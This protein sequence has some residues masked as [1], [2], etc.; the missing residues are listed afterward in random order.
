MAFEIKEE[1]GEIY[2]AIYDYSGIANL[3]M[4]I[5]KQTDNEDFEVTS[6]PGKYYSYIQPVTLTKGIY[7]LVIEPQTYFAYQDDVILR[8][9]LDV[10]YEKE[11]IT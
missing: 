10:L 5:V 2:A 1:E 7:H 9:G 8:F 11:N 6:I 3:G 4:S